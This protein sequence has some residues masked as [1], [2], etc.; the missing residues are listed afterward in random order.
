MARVKYLPVAEGRSL[1]IENFPNFSASG[2]V[3]GMKEK[4]YGQDAL[5][6]KCGSYIYNV[7]ERPEIY[8]GRAH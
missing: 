8:Y 7:T 6:V 4:Y 1:N 5:L 3:K 2:C